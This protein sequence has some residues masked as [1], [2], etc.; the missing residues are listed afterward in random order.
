MNVNTKKM[1]LASA[2]IFLVVAW[3]VLEHPFN[4]TPMI[5]VMLFSAAIFSKWSWKIIVPVAAI[6]LSD[7]LIELKNGY[8]FHSATGM[9]YG[10]FALIFVLG[11]FILQKINPVRVITAA[12]VGSIAFFLVTN[13]AL[14]YPAAAVPNPA[15]GHYPHNWTGILA[16]YEAGLPFYRNMVVGDLVFTIF[17]F[18]AY[19]LISKA[20]WF[21][22]SEL[23]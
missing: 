6:L 3:R 15:L 11:Y 2:L 23:A 13:F 17:L 4:A 14:F 20:Q 16:S 22:K 7:L 19:Y 21:T 1:L 5:A 10:T 9:V 8:G 12:L 18:G